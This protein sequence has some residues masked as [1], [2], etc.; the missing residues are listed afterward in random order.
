MP[1]D[2]ILKPELFQDKETFYGPTVYRS[3]TT[4]V[5]QKNW[6]WIAVYLFITLASIV[7]SYFTSGWVSVAVAMFVAVVTFMIG[8]H[9]I[10]EVITTTREI[11]QG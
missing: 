1:D 5:V 10:R 9:M 2:Q 11:P 8:L 7:A 4:R 6:L 3:V